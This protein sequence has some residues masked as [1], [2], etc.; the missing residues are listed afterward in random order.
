MGIALGIGARSNPLVDGDVFPNIVLVDIAWY[1]E[2]VYFDNAEIGYKLIDNDTI[3]VESYLTLDREAS[4]FKFWH[5][6]NFSVAV[7][8]PPAGVPNEPPDNQGSEGELSYIALDEV[9]DRKWAVN[10]GTRI[11]F[12]QPDSEIT[13]AVETDASGVHKGHK[14]ILSYE[15]FWAGNDWQFSIR[16][17]LTWKSDG[18]VNYY[19][20]I[21]E[22]DSP[23]ENVHYEASGGF[24][25]SIAILFTKKINDKWHWIANASYQKLHSGMTDSP[26]VDENNINNVFVGVGYRF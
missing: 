3:G 5:V 8:A 20:G 23:I 10:F 15:H 6:G 22:R 4:H 9:S 16:P 12:Y 24:Q 14:A 21:S 19:Y 11:H 1:G 18:L 17:S 2:Q 13:L 26:L 25:P 7:V